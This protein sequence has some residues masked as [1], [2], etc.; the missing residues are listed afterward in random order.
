MARPTRIDVAGGWYHVV[1]RGIERRRIFRNEECFRHFEQLLSNLP[2]RFGVR[3]HGYVLMGNHYH[4]QLETPRANLSKAVQWLNVAYSIW[5]NRRHRR[6]GPLFQGRFKAILHEAATHGATIN[7]YIHLNPVRVKRLGGHEA[8]LRA[9]PDGESAEEKAQQRVE[10]LNKYEWSSY[11][12]YIG[13]K[14]APNWLSTEEIL[15]SFGR[16]LKTR[17]QSYRRYMERAAGL[18]RCETEWKAEVKATVMV[19]SEKFV[20]RMSE[21]IKGDRREQKAVRDAG[22]Q[23]LGWPEIAGAVAKVWGIDWERVEQSRR[24]GAKAA[25]LFVGRRY[26]DRTLR[27]LGE[28]AGGM[29]YPAVAMTILRFERRIKNDPDAKTKIEKVLNML[30]VNGLLPEEQF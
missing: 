11:S 16:G 29:E 19:G 30:N 25:A 28:L 4:L 17:Q 14:K 9:E 21:L 26:S 7:Q 12:Y 5:Y 20:D 27:E 23:D 3:I 24:A 10:A 15:K 18:D 13:T 6:V 2:Q 22:K 1:N 8:R